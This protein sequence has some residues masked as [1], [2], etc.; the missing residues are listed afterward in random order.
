MLARIAL[1]LVDDFTAIHPVLQHEIKRTAGE[2]LAAIP[3]AI[4][5][6]P[7]LADNPGAIEVLLQFP[8]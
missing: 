8:D 6:R 3:T 5:G 4:G 2:R 1:I 7:D